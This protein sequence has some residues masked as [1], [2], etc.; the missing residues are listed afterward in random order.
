MR[1][2]VFGG[3]GFEGSGIV[4]DLIKSCVSEVVIADCNIDGAHILANE[5]NTSGTKV[6]VQFVDADDHNSL[7]EAIKGADAVVS[8]IGPFYSYGVKTI[9]AAIDAK[10]PYVDINDDYDST[11]EAFKFHDEAKKAGIPVI[12]GLGVTPGLSNVCVSYAAGKL[13]RVNTINISWIAGAGP[14]GHAVALHFFHALDGKIPIFIDN[15]YELISPVKEGKKSVRFPDPFGLVEVP[16]IGH[17][18][19]I[20]LPMFIQGVKT[21]TVRG[22]L[23]P[24]IVQ[25]TINQ[26]VKLGLFSMTPIKINETLIAPRD[27]AMEFFHTLME[28][29]ET[30]YQVERV[31]KSLPTPGYGS[32]IIE[33]VGDK[34]NST[35]KYTYVINADLCDA[36]EW[37]ASIGAQLLAGGEI[38][39][40]G[41]LA[42]EQCI[43][44]EPFFG[45]LKKR[46]IKISEVEE[47]IRVV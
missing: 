38:K 28:A 47:I 4:R 2:V 10:V 34:N 35:A 3:A 14:G 31:L 37:P 9:K 13:D 16:Y 33:V 26:I 17:S 41:V 23:Y 19:H 20:T 21:V 36:T 25:E 42:P 11:K 15:K 24:L 30:R 32:L 43:Q 45:E 44:P 5:F 8:A 18:E 46:G 29:E 22:S 39:Q 1:I 7:V 12:I 6:S 27:F 40:K